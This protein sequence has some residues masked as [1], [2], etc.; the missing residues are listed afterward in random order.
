MSQGLRQEALAD[1]VDVTLGEDALRQAEGIGMLGETEPARDRGAGGV[2]VDLAGGHAPRERGQ[3]PP[4]PPDAAP[5][6]PDA[7]TG[8]MD[9]A[10]QVTRFADR[11]HDH[12]SRISTRTIL[13]SGA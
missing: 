8:V 2:R 5:T 11:R 4:Q 9:V 3:P 1:V 13:P 10:E 6:H 12:A 7:T